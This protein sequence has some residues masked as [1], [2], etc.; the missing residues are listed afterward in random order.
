MAFYRG[1]N[2]WGLLGFSSDSVHIGSREGREQAQKDTV[3]LEEE[4]E[5]EA[6][7]FLEQEAIWNLSESYNDGLANETTDAYLRQV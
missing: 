2:G 7:E 5:R 6:A 4:H 3:K 1:S